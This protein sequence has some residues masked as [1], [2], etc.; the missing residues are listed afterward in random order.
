M[1]ELSFLGDLPLTECI[2]NIVCLAHSYL[3]DF[4]MT[5]NDCNAQME[6]KNHPM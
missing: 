5:L 3:N 6:A 1:T 2:F 4:C